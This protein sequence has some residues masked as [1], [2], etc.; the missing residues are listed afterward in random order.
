MKAEPTTASAA[1]L[2]DE[3]SAL[4]GGIGIL[5]FVL[6][7]LAL[8]MLALAAALMI[9][10]GL[11]ALGASLIFAL[12]AAPTLAARRVRA[13]RTRGANPTRP[14]RKREA[15]DDPAQTNRRKTNHE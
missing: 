4:A 8:P 1:G 11:A 6:W 14:L 7:P 10:A 13:A 9:A 2:F 5:T 15:P 12:V 3:L